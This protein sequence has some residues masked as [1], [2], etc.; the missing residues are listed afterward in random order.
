MIIR[1]HSSLG[2][3]ADSTLEHFGLTSA[4]RVFTTV[5]AVVAVHLWSLRI[6]VFPYL[7]ELAVGKLA[8]VNHRL[9][10]DNGRLLNIFGILNQCAHVTPDSFAE[11]LNN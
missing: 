4:P 9:S 7:E 5:M 1:W 6:P 2:D 3:Q 8:T 10:A 11:A